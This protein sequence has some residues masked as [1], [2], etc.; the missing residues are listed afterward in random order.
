MALES[1]PL[2]H[3]E[4]IRQKLRAF[5]PPDRVQDHHS[6]P[7]HWADLIASGH[8]DQFKETALLPDFLNDIFCGLLGYT[9]PAASP[10]SFTL[11]RE[12]TLAPKWG[13]M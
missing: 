8:A 13:C 7:S 2:F 11:S 6:K 3:P 12:T 10:E 4:V 5:R 1:E 9:G